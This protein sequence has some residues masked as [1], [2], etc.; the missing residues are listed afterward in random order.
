MPGLKF[1]YELCETSELV[2]LC[3][4]KQYR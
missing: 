2:L 1:L 4:I 3:D